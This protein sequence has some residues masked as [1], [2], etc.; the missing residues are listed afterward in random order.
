MGV[1]DDAIL[2]EFS[3]SLPAAVEASGEA[4]H[5]LDSRVH[6][7]DT[8]QLIAKLLLSEVIT[9]RIRHGGLTREQRIGLTFT[10]L[11]TVLRVE[12]KDDGSAYQPAMTVA[13]APEGV[14]NGEWGLM[15]VDAFSHAWGSSNGDGSTIWFELL[16]ID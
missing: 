2:E 14:A 16:L 8:Q 9:Y 7:P 13:N 4:R 12:V 3:I 1:V 5:V 11:E 15:I 6:V 10:R